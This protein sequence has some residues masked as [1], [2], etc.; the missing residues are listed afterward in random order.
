MTIA[1]N[2]FQFRFEP[3]QWQDIELQASNLNLIAAAVTSTVGARHPSLAFPELYKLILEN[4]QATKEQ[5]GRVVAIE[6]M[7]FKVQSNED[8]VLKVTYNFT[9][10]NGTKDETE[11][12]VKARNLWKRRTEAKRREITLY[13]QHEPRFVEGKFTVMPGN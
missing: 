6:A 5:D 12:A 10:R 2:T 8:D 9:V 13:P 3:G 11:I 1:K 7:T 4:H